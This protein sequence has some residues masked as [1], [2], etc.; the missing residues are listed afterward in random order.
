VL[1]ERPSVSSTAW[2]T[3]P[4]WASS[5]VS[6]SSSALRMSV[7]PPSWM[8]LICAWICAILSP[9]P[10]CWNGTTHCGSV[11]KASTPSRSFCRSDSVARIADSRAM[12]NFDGRSGTPMLADLSMI[13]S[14]ETSARSGRGGGSI[15]TGSAASSGVPLYAPRVKL[16][17][18]PAATRPRPSLRTNSRR[19]A[20]WSVERS[21]AGTSSSITLSYGSSNESCE[22][23]DA[24]GMRSASIPA[25]RSATRS[26]S[27]PPR[28]SSSRTCGGGA[29]SAVAAA[30]LLRSVPSGAAAT[31]A[32]SR[33]MPGCRAVSW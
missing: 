1:N 7:P 11:S 27:P 20:I 9:V 16:E 31:T 29:T 24:A 28:P 5:A 8:L 2:R 21:P 33:A 30:L 17:R 10:I 6:P 25:P 23:S 12:S 18:P 4:D 14:N 15:V 26:S 32:R 13:S 3:L 22:G 19:V